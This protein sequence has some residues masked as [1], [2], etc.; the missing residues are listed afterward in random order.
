MYTLSTLDLDSYFRLLKHKEIIIIYRITRAGTIR[1]THDS[2]LFDSNEY[3][4]DVNRYDSNIF[5][6]NLKEL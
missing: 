2:I 4:Y 5:V 3:S 1:L 6:S